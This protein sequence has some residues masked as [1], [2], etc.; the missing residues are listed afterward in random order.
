MNP[1]RHLLIAVDFDEVSERA[2]DFGLNLAGPLGARVTVMHA[3]GLP[4]LN[5]LEGEYIPTATSAAHKADVH[6]K[7]LDALVEPRKERGAAFTALL[8]VGSAPEEICAVAKEIG[9]DMIV[10]GTHGR[11]AVGRAILGNVAH[12]VLRTA[13]VPVL[14]VK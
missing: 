8:R 9:A 5:A 11:G 2:L 3:Y 12:T 7:Q 14:T 4:V 10:V 6:Q 13:S 1:I